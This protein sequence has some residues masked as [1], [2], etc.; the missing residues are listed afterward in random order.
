MTYYNRRFQL[1]NTLKSIT[2]SSFKNFEVIVVDDGSDPEYDIQDLE[3]HYTFLKVIRINPKHKHWHNPCIPYNIA[4]KFAI[5][6][7]IIIQNSE[8]IHATDILQ[9]TADNITSN[10][11]FIYACLNIDHNLTR[12]IKLE[13]FN[14]YEYIKNLTSTHNN[15]WY[16]HSQ[17][18]NKK[19]HFCTALYTHQLKKLNG[20]N[21]IFANGYCFDDN[22]FKNR[23]CS[24]LNPKT[25]DS[26]YV[27]HQWHLKPPIHMNPNRTKYIELEN[28]NKEIYRK[29]YP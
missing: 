13:D 23:A 20:F 9:Y 19:Y 5:G 24:L 14:S 12:Q 4:F 25:I 26:H 18:R 2:L 29:L 15:N 27:I 6:E 1:L 16:Q 10:D 22:D 17:Y 7:I 11:Y 21:E 28:I 8:N 3:N